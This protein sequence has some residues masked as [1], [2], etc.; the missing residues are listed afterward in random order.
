M[1]A[2]AYPLLR[3]TVEF[4]RHLV[5]KEADGRYHLTGTHAHEDFWGVGD[6]IMDL[7]AIRGTAP[8]AIR[9]AEI[10]EVDSELRSHWKDVKRTGI[11][12]LQFGAW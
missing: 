12:C 10:L 11:F 6:S 1:A 3:G 4:Y 5:K 8:L 9:A 7:A 2:H